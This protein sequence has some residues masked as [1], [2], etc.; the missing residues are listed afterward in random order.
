MSCSSHRPS[1]SQTGQSSG[2]VVRCFSIA[3]FCASRSW[4][5]S[6]WV[7]T[8]MP[9]VIGAVQERTGAFLPSTSTR[10]IPQEPKGEKV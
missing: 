4:G 10:Q 9:A 3:F 8:T 5:A 6:S 1:A 2:W 7:R